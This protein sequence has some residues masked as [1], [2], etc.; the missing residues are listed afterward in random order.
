MGQPIVIEQ[1][2]GADGNIGTD[3]VAKSAP[4][5]Y[6]WLASSF[7][8]TVAPALHA[9]LSFDPIKDFRA[10]ALTATAPNVL[11]VAPQVPASTIGDFIAYAKANPGRVFYAIPANGSSAH[12]GT[13][14]LKR[15]AGFEATQVLYKGAPAALLDVIAGRVQFMLVSSSLAA[16]Q[17]KAGKLKALAVI[18]PKRSPLL[19]GV[20][21]IVEAGYAAALV[22]PWFGIH[23][24]AGTPDPIVRKINQGVAA[25]LATPDVRARLESAG[26][27]PAE[28]RAPNEV[29]ASLQ[30]EVLRWRQL[31][32]QIDLSSK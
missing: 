3:A 25:A 13:E 16:P 21:T 12:I 20:P 31:A 14:V 23:V 11:V 32:K 4:D 30:E 28:P 15:Q 27:T 19:P 26:L 7:P 5:G 24:P 18:A 2:L 9:S 22:V 6:T 29:D 1:K 8:L 17:V 10:V